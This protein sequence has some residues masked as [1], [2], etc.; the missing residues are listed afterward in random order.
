MTLN[1]IKLCCYF[2]LFFYLS[3]C[4]K[5]KLHLVN[6]G[7][8]DKQMNEL[9]TALKNQGIDVTLS[10]ISMPKEFPSSAIALNP[11][12]RDSSFLDKIQT[13]L[14]AQDFEQATE[15]RFAQGN[16]FYGPNHVG[17]YLRNELN[18]NSKMPPY[19]RTQYCKNADSTMMFKANG[20]FILEYEAKNY[21]D[22]LQQV[23]GKYSFNGRKL[24]LSLHS[25]SNSSR[26]EAKEHTFIL[27]Q[28][29]RPTPF[30]DKP[31]DVFKPQNNITEKSHTLKQLTCD[32]LIIYMN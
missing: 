6:Q 21:D 15:L 31:A 18:S 8:S 13:I 32:F 14:I 4:T 26:N 2:L 28:E 10:T 9:A 12:F 23:H 20:E 3:G 5:T 17:L 1:V 7:Y 22:K 24:T 29:T 25:S 11:N 27:H 30:G 16:H 19:L